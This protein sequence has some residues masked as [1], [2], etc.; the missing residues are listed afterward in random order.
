M[1]QVPIEEFDDDE[2]LYDSPIE[3]F[4]DEPVIE[5]V[6]ENKG[7]LSKLL[8][9]ATT[10]F[11]PGVEEPTTEEW[12][13]DPKRSAIKSFGMQLTTPLAIAG[14]TAGL[15]GGIAKFRQLRKMSQIAGE[16]PNPNILARTSPSTVKV[17]S[18]IPEIIS[19]AKPRAIDKLVT[20]ITEAQPLRK[21]QEQLYTAER[22]SKMQRMQPALEIPGEEG[23]FA[24]LGAL[25]GE[26]TKLGMPALRNQLEQPDVDEL[27][28]MIWKAPIG[29]QFT[30]IHAGQGLSKILK[31]DIPQAS[32]L[33][34]MRRVFGD[35][36][37]DEAINKMKLVDRKQT[38]VSEVVNLPRSLMASWD[39]SA[40]LRQGLPMINRKQFWTSLDDMFKSWGSEKAFRATQEAIE[41]S[42]DFGFAVHNKL[43]LTD[44]T[45]LSNREEQFMSTWAEKI[46]G[47]RRSNRAY[48]A[49]LNK[50]RFDT[51]N[52][53]VKDATAI[54]KDPKTDL[55]LARNL[56]EFVN[57][58]TGRGSLGKLERHAPL[59]N[60]TLFSP[61]LIA[62]RVQML[63]PNYYY[64][65]D[66]FTRKQALKALFSVAGAGT[67][68]ATLGSMAGGDVDMNPTSSDFGKIQIGNTRIDPYGGFQQ[69][70]VAASKLIS[71]QS[72]STLSGNVTDLTAG[73]F[74]RPTRLSVAA[75]FGE[76]KLH[77]VLTFA[78]EMLRG[79]NFQGQ[80]SSIP[81]EIKNRV[82]PIIIQDVIDLA[83]EEPELLPLIV[84]S[85]F[86][87]G[88][89]TYGQE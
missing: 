12:I 75:K 60:S 3:E 59:L 56:A 37:I 20:A 58:S 14:E 22:A 77:P 76:S 28:S 82:L 45:N 27:F 84:P 63:N 61:R 57:N 32:E 21:S 36:L 68:I 24:R 8:K 26:H 72:T 29:D 39:F 66:P 80:P 85:A 15:I 1:A 6:P 83:K 79:T 40:P 2:P 87:M 86:G 38:L 52:S 5:E 47:V 9:A 71:G 11:I 62:S 81:E 18:E 48:V 34:I 25:K 41:Q 23:L 13:K 7:I 16:I 67:T 64:R 74:G 19:P 54:G 43:Q 49:F 51:F 42:P 89:Q 31:G 35:E 4:D 17:S 30:K 50:L 33:K 70:I 69:Y 55:T 10:S 78:I 46:P 73:E 53:L 88:I 65:L 44:L